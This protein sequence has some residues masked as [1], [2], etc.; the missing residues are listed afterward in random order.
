MNMFAVGIQLKILVG[1]I[2]LFL[3]IGMLP[4]A[5]NFIVTE[6]QKMMNLF[7]NAMM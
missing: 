6:T 2:V 5:A 7:I 4:S 3:T 1:L